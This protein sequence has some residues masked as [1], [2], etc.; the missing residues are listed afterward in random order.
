MQRVKEEMRSWESSTG[1]SRRGKMNRRSRTS[2]D[3]NLSMHSHSFPELAR[4]QRPREVQESCGK[5]RRGS[6]ELPARSSQIQGSCEPKDDEE[7]IGRR[8]RRK[9][10]MRLLAGCKKPGEEKM[11]RTGRASLL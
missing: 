10:R 11:E 3:S 9:E 1:C 7:E 6:M 5:E 4:V 2:R 8:R